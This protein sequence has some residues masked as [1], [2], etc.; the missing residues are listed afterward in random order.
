MGGLGGTVAPPPPKN[1]HTHN[2]KTAR[3]HETK[4]GP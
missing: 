4:R 3:Q 1:A 2:D